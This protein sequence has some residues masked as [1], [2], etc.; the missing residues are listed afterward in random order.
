M[1]AT[2][3]DLS[4]F[5][6]GLAFVFVIIVFIILRTRGINR[7][8]E[9]IIAALRMTIQLVIVGFLLT[10]IFDH[11]HPIITFS[12]VLLM[13]GFAVFTVFQKFKKDLTPSLKRVV[14]VSIPLGALPVLL[15]FLIV[16]VQVSPYYNPQYFI[17]ITGMIVGNSMTGI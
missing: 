12:I 6:V 17:P 14:V 16:V 9:L 1:L 8:K 3:F 15:Y 2:V 7:D 5:Q 11:P 4:I 13:S 10:Y